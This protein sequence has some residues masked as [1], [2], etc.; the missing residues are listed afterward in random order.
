MESTRATRT[1]FPQSLMHAEDSLERM[2]PHLI[3]ALQSQITGQN[4]YFPPTASFLQPTDEIWTRPTSVWPL[5][6]LYEG[7]PTQ[8]FTQLTS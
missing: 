1:F 4:S 2:L 7:Q 3:R 5:T 6:Q 8:S